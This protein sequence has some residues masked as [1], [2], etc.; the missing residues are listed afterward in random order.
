MS[1]KAVLNY[2]DYTDWEIHGQLFK[3]NVKDKCKM[4]QPA[5]NYYTIDL[6]EFKF[7]PSCSIFYRLKII[8]TD[9]GLKYL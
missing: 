7:S 9:L 1:S 8:W 2:T 5:L 6:S 4:V 3:I